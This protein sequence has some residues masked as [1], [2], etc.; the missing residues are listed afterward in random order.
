MTIGLLAAH[1]IQ[2]GSYVAEKDKAA[3]VAQ[4]E[5]EASDKADKAVLLVRAT[6]DALTPV[7]K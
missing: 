1:I 7:R 2:P 4:F 5:T 6:L 3:L